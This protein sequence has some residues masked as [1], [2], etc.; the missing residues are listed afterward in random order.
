[1]NPEDLYND[2][3]EVEETS[4]VNGENTLLPTTNDFGLV[5]CRWSIMTW[6]L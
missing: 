1:M 2:S 4:M 3:P 6:D 5:L